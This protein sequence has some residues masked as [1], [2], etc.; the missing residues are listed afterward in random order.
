MRIQIDF[1]DNRAGIETKATAYEVNQGCLI[2]KHK[3][4]GAIIYFPLDCI[5]AFL[6]FKD[7]NEGAIRGK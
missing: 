6:V 2:L 4:K 3:E 7:D 1:R 5:A